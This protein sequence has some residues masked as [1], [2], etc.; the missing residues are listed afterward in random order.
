M[1]QQAPPDPLMKQGTRRQQMAAFTIVAATLTII[2]ALL[3]A[4]ACYAFLKANAPGDIRNPGRTLIPA[5]EGLAAAMAVRN[6]KEHQPI[7]HHRAAIHPENLENF[8]SHL[9]D[10]AQRNGWFAYRETNLSTG[11]IMPVE[12]LRTLDG[13]EADPIGWVTAQTAADRNPKR[14]STLNLVKVSVSMAPYRT[15]CCP[16][17]SGP[18]WLS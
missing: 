9:H 2:A 7:F 8:R 16:K 4:G 5:P 13:L 10:A 14:P 1:N 3:A 18:R 11:L 6:N 15:Y 12:D 17:S